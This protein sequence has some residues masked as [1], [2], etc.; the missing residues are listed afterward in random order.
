MKQCYIYMTD[1]CTPELPVAVVV[2]TRLYKIKPV[3]TPSPE[4]AG[5]HKPPTLAEKILTTDDFWARQVSF[6]KE[7]G[8]Q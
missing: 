6:L 7:H 3:N 1:H 8:L 5:A 2:S 4:G